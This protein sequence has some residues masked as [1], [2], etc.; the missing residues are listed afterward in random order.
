MK[1]PNCGKETELITKQVGSNDNNEPVYNKFAV[2][3][4]CKKKW[5]LDKKKSSSQTIKPDMKEITSSDSS[6]SKT[7]EVPRYANIPSEKIRKKSEHT[8]RQSYEDMLAADPERKPVKRKKP[9]PDAAKKRPKKAAPSAE[10]HPKKRSVSDNPAAS[11]PRKKVVEEKKPKFKL[12]R[13]IL[14]VLSLVAGVYFGYMTLIEGLSSITS[15]TGSAP[16]TT[17]A[18][19]ALVFLVAGLLTICMKNMRTIIPF[20]LPFIFYVAC[21]FFS[22]L[23]MRGIDTLKYGTI[24]CAAFAVI[25]FI[26][27][28][29]SGKSSR[30]DDE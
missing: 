11:R 22:L 7:K 12:F 28:L 21:A 4:D 26:L 9:D 8:V 10:S 5:N 14:A 13:I 29:L 27:L 23:T 6:N 17:G 30:D 19:L 25:Y 16:G 24:A 1:C 20:I 3:K 15:N 18:I 2:C